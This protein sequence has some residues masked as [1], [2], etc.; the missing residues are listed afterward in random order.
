MFEVRV[1]DG[2][3]NLKEV[4]TSEDVSRR[5]DE[6]FYQGEQTFARLTVKTYVCVEC[7]V[8]FE[9]RSS[10]GDKYCKDCR[11]IVYRNRKRRA[12]SN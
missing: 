6:T 1:F 9:S 2:R 3:G 7:K 10:R 5:Y 11:K 8:N 12:L 4:I